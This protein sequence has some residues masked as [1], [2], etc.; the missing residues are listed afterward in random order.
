MI[1]IAFRSGLSFLTSLALFALSTSAEPAA[2]SPAPAQNKLTGTNSAPAAAKPIMHSRVF[3][4]SDM[5]VQPSNIGVFRGAFDDPTA[6]M[7]KFSCH[8]DRKST[9]LN[10]SHVSES[11]MP[12]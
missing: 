5:R 8:I 10:S 1:I 9:R 11:R 3:Q 2:E 4:W 12:S 6:T 7:D